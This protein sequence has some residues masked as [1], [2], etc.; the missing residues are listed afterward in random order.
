MNQK[1]QRMLF[2]IWS[3]K[4]QNLPVLWLCIGVYDQSDNRNANLDSHMANFGI[5]LFKNSKSFQSCEL[6]LQ[7]MDVFWPFFGVYLNKHN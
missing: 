2:Y 4:L 7:M 3:L 1:Y 5:L 6:P